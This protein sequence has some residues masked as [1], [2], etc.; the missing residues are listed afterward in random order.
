MGHDVGNM[1]NRVRG[2]AMSVATVCLGADTLVTLHSF[3]WLVRSPAPGASCCTQ[4]FQS[5]VCFCLAQVP[6]T[7][8]RS[9]AEIER[10]W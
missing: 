5:P 10:W 2:R 6:E 8:G 9:L 1:S 4:P 3:R 7:K